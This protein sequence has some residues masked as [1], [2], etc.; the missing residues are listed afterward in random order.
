MLET[1]TRT[2]MADA[3]IKAARSLDE[4]SYKSTGLI[5]ID[6]RSDARDMLALKHNRGLNELIRVLNE[7]IE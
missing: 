3:I 5:Q 6:Y 1:I 2:I 4:S 7:T